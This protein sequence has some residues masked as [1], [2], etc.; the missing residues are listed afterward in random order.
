MCAGPWYRCE[1]GRR[2]AGGRPCVLGAPRSRSPRAASAETRKAARHWTLTS[3]CSGRQAGATLATAGREDRAA[4]TG[5]HA[6]AEAVGLR[7]TAVVR[8][9]G[10]LAHSGTPEMCDGGTSPGCHRAPTRNS[11]Y[12]QVHRF[13]TSPL[14]VVVAHRRQA[15]A[16]I[17]NSTWSR[18]ARLRHPV[19]PAAH[20]GYT[21]ASRRPGPCRARRGAA[22]YRAWHI[23]AHPVD[24]DLNRAPW[25]DYRG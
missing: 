7:A 22:Q 11:Q 5:T 18:Y 14:G 3:G 20:Q 2:G 21:V 12:A 19:K 25:P 8:L 23:C 6:Q 1:G 15:A 24:N 17:D 10:A 13:M 9:E 16:A 4:G